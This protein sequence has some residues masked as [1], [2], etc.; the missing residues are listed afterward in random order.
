VAGQQE[1][2][3]PAANNSVDVSGKV[4]TGISA[5]LAASPASVS[6]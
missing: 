1:A 4:P 3:T 5:G 6:R 2:E